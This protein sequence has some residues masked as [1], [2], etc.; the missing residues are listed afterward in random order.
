[1]TVMRPGDVHGGEKKEVVG[2]FTEAPRG[3]SGYQ[4]FSGVFTDFRGILWKSLGRF[5][6]V[7]ERIRWGFRG[8]PGRLKG[9]PYG[10]MSASASKGLRGNLET[11]REYQEA[12]RG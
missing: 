3:F 9:V 11:F 7:S 12:P 10:L 2:V 4:E 1:M 6:G 5:R 8:V